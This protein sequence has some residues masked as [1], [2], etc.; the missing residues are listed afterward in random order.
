M[1]LASAR[2]KR[3]NQRGAVT[4]EYVILVATVT[5]GLAFAVAFLGPHLVG[6]YTHARD[7]LISPLP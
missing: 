1:S 2:P 7:T 5:L 6:S 3:R 4:V